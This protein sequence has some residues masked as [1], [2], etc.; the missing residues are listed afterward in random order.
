MAYDSPADDE[1]YGFGPSGRGLVVAV[2]VVK[3]F[4]QLRKDQSPEK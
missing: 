1:S 3:L 2:V 4:Q